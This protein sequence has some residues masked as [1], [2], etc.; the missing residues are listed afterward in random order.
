VLRGRALKAVRSDAQ[1]MTQGGSKD[2]VS[3]LI[4]AGALVLILAGFLL[5]FHVI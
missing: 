2:R 3:L 4:M 1:A 5:L